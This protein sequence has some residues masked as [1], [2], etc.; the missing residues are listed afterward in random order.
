VTEYEKLCQAY[1]E[2][3]P[4][5][6]AIDRMLRT[7]PLKMRQ[8]ISDHLTVPQG[9]AALPTTVSRIQTAYVDLFWPVADHGGQRTW[10]RCDAEHCLRTS[11]DGIYAF[12]LVSVLKKNVALS[13]RR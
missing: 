1:F 2:L 8:A 13:M 7:L 6:I 10:E 3:E 12:V 4:R 11:A 9:A 5:Q